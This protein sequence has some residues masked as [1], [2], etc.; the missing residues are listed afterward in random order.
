MPWAPGRAGGLAAGAGQG[1]LDGGAGK[2]VQ[3]R[4][5]AA[6]PLVPQ[7]W[8]PR[9]PWDGP[10]NSSRIYG[11]HGVR[12]LSLPLVRQ[13]SHAG[14]ASSSRCFGQHVLPR[15]GAAAAARSRQERWLRSEPAGLQLPRA[16][17][18]PST[19]STALPPLLLP[20]TATPTPR[21]PVSL[22]S[23]PHAF[24]LPRALRVPTHHLPCHLQPGRSR[25]GA[26][27][28]PP[29]SSA[30]PLPRAGGN[31]ALRDAAVHTGRRRGGPAGWAWRARWLLPFAPF[32]SLQAWFSDTQPEA[33]FPALGWGN[34]AP[35]EPE[36]TGSVAGALGTRHEPRGF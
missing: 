7:P 32:P 27:G 13:Q 34:S 3:R 28:P 30:L 17:P 2:L 25:G 15:R 4:P 18:G 22:H 8:R 1:A 23:P 10:R 24:L 21:V 36:P 31:A 26:H 29:P 19:S 20:P 35:R 14:R 33:A 9:A 5:P 6:W 12:S 16:Q 11:S